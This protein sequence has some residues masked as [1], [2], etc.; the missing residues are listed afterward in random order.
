LPLLSAV[1]LVL[2]VACGDSMTTAT[3]T[4]TE[5]ASS[6]PTQNVSPAP[7]DVPSA[8]PTAPTLDFRT[9][10][11]PVTVVMETDVVWMTLGSITRPEPVAG[12]T[13]VT[14][15]MR[16][17]IRMLDAGTTNY[18]LGLEDDS[19]N[20]YEDSGGVLLGSHAKGEEFTFETSIDVPADATLTL[21]HMQVEGED[22]PKL[23]YHIDLP[24]S[25]IPVWPP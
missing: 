16:G 1:V 7:S 23:S 19:G 20:V 24:V 14:I 5:R 4:P 9:R 11:L 3:V 25:D 17:S 22:Y 6:T 8:T 2:L 10:F 18:R 13:Q 21:I 12:E 15:T